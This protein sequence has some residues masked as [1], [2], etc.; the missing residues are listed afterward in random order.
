MLWTTETSSVTNDVYELRT[1]ITIVLVR[2]KKLRIKSLVSPS[3]GKTTQILSLMFDYS[4]LV[5]SFLV[6]SPEIEKPSLQR[7]NY[8]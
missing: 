5:S 8:N 2:K 3:L 1:Q 4:R 6:W 7:T